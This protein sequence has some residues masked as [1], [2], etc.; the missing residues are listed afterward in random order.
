MTED[1]EDRQMSGAVV[2]LPSSR[3]RL[4]FIEIVLAIVRH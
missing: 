2:C 3:L 1:A 4:A